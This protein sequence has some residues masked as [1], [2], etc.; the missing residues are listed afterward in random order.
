MS[1]NEKLGRPIDVP[2]TWTW[3]RSNQTEHTLDC[4]P[5]VARSMIIG[6]VC[7]DRLARRRLPRLGPSAL[8]EQLPRPLVG[9]NDHLRT[10]AEDGDNHDMH[11]AQTSHAAG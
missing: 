1:G 9:R 2:I 7:V 11:E 8:P 10:A 6:E 4:S 5:V 3:A